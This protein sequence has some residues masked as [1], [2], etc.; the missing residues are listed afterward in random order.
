MHYLLFLLLLLLFESLGSFVGS[1][2]FCEVSHV[3]IC[4]LQEVGQALVFLLINQF[5]VAFLIL[6]LRKDTCAGYI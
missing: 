3:L 2:Q 1:D 6:G 4:L 5:A